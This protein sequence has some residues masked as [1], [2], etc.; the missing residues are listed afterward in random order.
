MRKQDI[1]DFCSSPN[2]V[3]RYQCV[4]FESESKS[5][6][7]LYDGSGTTVGPTNLVFQSIDYWAACA[8]CASFVD[9][10]DIDGLLEYVTKTLLDEKDSCLTPL[11]R[12]QIIQHLRHTYEL[13]FKTRIR[14]AQ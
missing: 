3:C 2:T 12:I 4:D 9:A 11:R 14:V 6:G 13:F 8:A 7:V 5:A 10:E 1:C